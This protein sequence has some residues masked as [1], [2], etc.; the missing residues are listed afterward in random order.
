MLL[1]KQAVIAV[2]D[3]YLSRRISQNYRAVGAVISGRFSFVQ[4]DRFTT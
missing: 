2:H 1:K 4:I 3:H